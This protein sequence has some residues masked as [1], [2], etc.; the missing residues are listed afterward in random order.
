[1]N[2]V[3]VTGPALRSPIHEQ[4]VK[5][6]MAR[7][8]GSIAPSVLLPDGLVVT[9]ISHDPAVITA[10]RNDPLVHD[11]VSLGFGK[12]GLSATD[13]TWKHAGEF[14]PPLLL[15]HGTADRIT[16]PSSSRD[17]AELAAKNNQ[18]VLLKLWDGMYHEVHNK[19]HKE[20]VFKCMIDWLG[21]HS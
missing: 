9:D 12:S 5:A 13:Y 21:T 6:L 10:Y 2:G 3:V 8:L 20:Q 14:A 18:D 17:F 11:R 19:P 16:Y 1:M 15:M 7:A 4:K